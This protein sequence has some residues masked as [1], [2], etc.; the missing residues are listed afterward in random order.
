MYVDFNFTRF[1]TI[2]RKGISESKFVIPPSRKEALKVMNPIP[3]RLYGLPKIHKDGVPIRPI[4]SFISSPTYKLAKYLNLWFRSVTGFQSKYSLQNS[5]DLIEKLV[6]CPPPPSNSKLVSFDAASLFTNVPLTP[7][8]ERAHEILISANVPPSAADE[9]ISLLKTCLYPNICQ[10]KNEIYRFKDGLPM[11]SPL[12]P[13]LSE[14]FM[15]I[16]EEK[17]FNS[18]CM[19]LQYIVYWHRYVDDVLCL[20]TGSPDLLDEFLIFLNSLYPSIRFTLEV[21]GQSIN[22]LDLTISLHE[23]K[24]DFE[25]Y[26]KPTYTD[27]VI[28]GN[29]LPRLP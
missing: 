27:I 5:S 28:N 9:F 25:I 11:G 17:V 22:F 23:G 14:I 3:P 4:V 6:D 7:T 29:I 21:G 13:L 26:R 1:N 8:L 18:Q 12:A 16:F 19:L 20:W 10:F 24:H 15:S 2:V